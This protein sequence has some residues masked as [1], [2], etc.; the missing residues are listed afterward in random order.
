L[1]PT[2]QCRFNGSTLQRFTGAARGRLIRQLLAESLLLAVAGGAL[3]VL[4]AQWGLSGRGLLVVGQ[5]ALSIILVIGAALLI[6]SFARLRSVDPGFQPANLLTMK[7][8]LPPARHD[9][10]QKKAAFF[11]ELVQRVEV[12]PGVREATVVMSLPTTAVLQTNVKV[13]GQPPVDPREQPSVQIQ[14]IMP[15]Y[16][17]TLGIPLRQ[18]REFAARDNARGATP[19]VIVNESFARRFWRTIRVGGTRSASTW[20]RAPIN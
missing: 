9:T 3:G 11:E 6:E 5:V 17:H 7:I 12:V 10:E 16:F 4:L 18:G 20:G 19:V 2:Y 15:G 14:S 8:A 13:E 1:R